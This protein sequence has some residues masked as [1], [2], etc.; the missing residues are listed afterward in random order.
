[1]PDWV[2]CSCSSVQTTFVVPTATISSAQSRTLAGV[3]GLWKYID[4]ERLRASSMSG[5]MAQGLGSGYAL[6]GSRSG[7]LSLHRP[8]FLRVSSEAFI[9][10]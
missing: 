5:F 3:A 6:R 1:M 4:T 7:T 9:A 8:R 10:F 2:S